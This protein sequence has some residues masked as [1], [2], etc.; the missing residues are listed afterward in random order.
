[1]SAT[2]A[3]YLCHGPEAMQPDAPTLLYLATD[4]FP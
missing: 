4:V 2:I 1:M 3:Q